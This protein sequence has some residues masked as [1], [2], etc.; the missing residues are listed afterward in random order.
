MS[1]SR[2]LRNLLFLT[3]VTVML[4]S[5][6]ALLGP[7]NVEIPLERLQQTIAGRFPFNN[8]YLELIDVRVANP[9]VSL[10]AGTN[11]ILTSMDASVA[12][13]FMEKSWTGNLAVSGQ[14]KV[15]P[16]RS[17]LVLSEPRVET[18]NIDGMDSRFA[19]YF[20]RAAGLLAE[21]LLQDMPVYTFRPDEFRY[22]GVNFLPTKITTGTSSL[23]VTFEPAK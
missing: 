7:R 4:S 3:V 20:T 13:P 11:R 12:P 21:Q 19:S 8:R 18:L 22:G 5:C 9:R 16:S 23:V 2:A 17:A 15:D 1:G 6:A 10:Q 14:L